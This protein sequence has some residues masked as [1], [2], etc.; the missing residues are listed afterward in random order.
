MAGP[1]LKMLFVVQVGPSKIKGPKSQDQRTA[2]LWCCQC[3]EEGLTSSQKSQGVSCAGAFP[4]RKWA[5]AEHPLQGLLWVRGLP[6]GAPSG[7]GSVLPLH[8][9][10][11]DRIGKQQQSPWS[12]L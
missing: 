6:L 11:A 1:H 7:V 8:P 12:G 10:G 9:D 3:Q 2:E 5:G 4:G